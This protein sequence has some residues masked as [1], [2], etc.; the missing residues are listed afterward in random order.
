LWCDRTSYA[1]RI[2][3]RRDA[4]EITFGEPIQCVSFWLASG[5]VSYPPSNVGPLRSLC[6]VA[7]SACRLIPFSP[8]MGSPAPSCSPELAEEWLEKPGAAKACPEANPVRQCFRRARSSSAHRA[9][10]EILNPG[11]RGRL[12]GASFAHSAVE[13]ME[14]DSSWNR[15]SLCQRPLRGRN[16]LWVEVSLGV[17]EESPP[18]LSS[19]PGWSPSGEVPFG[20]T[21][22]LR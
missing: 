8:A 1:S 15:G 17:A 3:S 19:L 18:W 4:E 9:L 16:A 13:P 10:I 14:Q 11:R 20:R 21:G 22:R 7:A 5:E 6:G 2:R 12:L